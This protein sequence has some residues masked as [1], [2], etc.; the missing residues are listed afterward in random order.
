MGL[1][2]KIAGVGLGVVGAVTGQP[3]LIGAGASIL[4]GGMAADASKDA[5][6][7]Q[8]ES[9]DKAMAQNT[10]VYN[11]TAG[12]QRQIYDN[13][14]A[15]L[16]P[17][18]TVGAGAMGNMGSMVG[19][20]PSNLTPLSQVANGTMPVGGGQAAPMPTDAAAATPQVK[21]SL[22]TQSGYTQQ[23]EK[24]GGTGRTV[25]LRAPNGEVKAVP[26]TQAEAYVSRGA[27]RLGVA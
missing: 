27:Q 19:L 7:T 26:D 13:T 15:D 23:G 10:A 25:L 20:P 22:A 11:Q 8:S 16:A 5:A 1:W 9:A 6:K 21:A 14:Q 17:Y 18:K 24:R 4:T 3:G 12:T 2:S